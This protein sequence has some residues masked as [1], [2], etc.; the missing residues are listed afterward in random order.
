MEP[1]PRKLLDQVRDAIRLKHYSYKT[2]QTYVGW[3][4]RYILFHNK[5]HPKEMGSAEIEAFLTHLAVEQQVS[6]STQNQAFS[7]LL[8]LYRQVLNQDLGSSINAVRARPSRYLP[9]VLTKAEVRS[10]LSRVTKSPGLVIQILYGSGLRLNEGLRLRVKDLDF[11]QRQIIVRDAKG[12]ESRVTMLPSS[13]IDPLRQHLQHVRRLHQHDLDR[14]YGSVYLPFALERK[15]PYADRAWIWQFVFPS[16]SRSKDPR[17]GLVR[18]HHLHESSVQRTLKQAVREAG[19]PK[20]VSCHTFRH[21]FA[22][23]LLEDGYDIRTVQELLGHKDVKTTMIYTH[24]LN[25]GGCGVRSPL[26]G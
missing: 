10:I 25:R 23:H 19:I 1:R 11:A 18:R 16:L 6:A 4:R 24:V 7:A 26:D 5:Q 22:T 3:I 14:G 20:R 9:T 21:S 13:L 17:S 8:F 12:H 15:Y 2:E